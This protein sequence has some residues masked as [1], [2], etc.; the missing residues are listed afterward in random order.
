MMFKALEQAGRSYRIVSTSATTA[1][2]M[3]TAQAGLA[4][5]TVLADDRLPDDLRIVA[6]DEGLPALPD[7][8]YLMLKAR[9]PRQPLTDILSTQVLDV[10]ASA[11]D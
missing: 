6:D 10:F 1:G 9:N 11:S 5:T 4:V 3:A 2:Q 8:R 7:C